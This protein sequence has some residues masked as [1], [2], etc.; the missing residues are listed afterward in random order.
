MVE[1]IALAVSAATLAGPP[2]DDGFDWVV[3]GDPG[4]R[5]TIPEEVPGWPSLEIG[6]VDH[7][8]RLSLTEVTVEQ[9]FEFVNAYWPYYDDVDDWGFTGDWIYPTNPDPGPGEDPGYVIVPGSE[10]VPTNMA[11][12][13]AARYCNWLHNAKASERWAFEG[14]VYDTSDFTEGDGP[15]YGGPATHEP[16]ALVWIP[17]HDELVKGLYYDPHRYGLGGGGYWMHPDGG[18]DVL[19]SGY[20][21][22]GGETS[23]GLIEL[24]EFPVA[25]YPWVRSPWG[26]LDGSGGRSEWTELAS[27]Q[28]TRFVLCSET[29]DI[30]YSTWDR[31]DVALGI[32]YD[33]NL[34]EPGLRLAM[35][36]CAPDLNEDGLLNVLDFVA[37]QQAFVHGDGADLNW[38]GVLNVLDLIAFIDLYRDGCNWYR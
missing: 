21:E 3:V 29:G 20:P 35:P 6:A 18:M 11:W 1:N 16:D 36:H 30:G 28:G 8:Y 14:G 26:L 5:D 7:Y 38:D 32:S 33:P 27:F 24:I 37:F 22:D 34:E 25:Q 9:W 4:N 2:M 23:G 12:Y 17:T 19:I 13:M 15:P 31:L 10:Q